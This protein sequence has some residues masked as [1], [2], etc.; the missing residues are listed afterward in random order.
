MTEGSI[1]TRATRCGG[2]GAQAI[3]FGAL[4]ASPVLSQ[5][6]SMHVKIGR[7]DPCPC[8]SGRKYKR[9]CIDEGHAATHASRRGLQWTGMDDV[10][11]VF[12]RADELD[13]ASNLMADGDTRPSA[14][15]LAEAESSLLVHLAL[16][17]S[18]DDK[19]GV[20]AAYCE[21]GFVYEALGELDAA[22]AM[23]AEALDLH[24]ALGDKEAMAAAYGSLGLV[25]RSGGDGAQAAAM[26]TSALTLHKALGHTDGMAA[27][28]G[29]LGLAYQM[30]GDEARAA[31]MYK[32]SIALYR[33]VDAPRQV[34]QIEGLLATLR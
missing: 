7:N 17:E 9:C 33:Q 2:V 13:S 26:Y 34:R 14:T 10:T 8:G 25:Y 19:E 5:N 21:L 4:V 3:V 24:E 18:L 29:N 27:D 20:A 15:E 16:Y 30:I 6:G 23:Y 12:R 11:P 31:A 28:C 32:D 22:I 1:S